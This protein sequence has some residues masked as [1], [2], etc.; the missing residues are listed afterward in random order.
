MPE[1]ARRRVD[2]GGRRGE[3][4]ATTRRMRRTRSPGCEAGRAGGVKHQAR[5]AQSRAA[6]GSARSQWHDQRVSGGGAVLADLPATGSV[7]WMSH[8]DAAVSLPSG[9]VVTARTEG[10]VT[11]G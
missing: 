2:R 5:D 1:P 11:E 3:Q 9:G 8:N 7:V 6:P 10:G 4:R